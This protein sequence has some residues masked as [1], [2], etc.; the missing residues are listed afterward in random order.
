MTGAGT[1]TIG[2]PV[3]GSGAPQWG[4]VGACSLTFSPH[5]QQVFR[6]M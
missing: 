4:Q 2:P 6:A 1:P 5:S 3:A